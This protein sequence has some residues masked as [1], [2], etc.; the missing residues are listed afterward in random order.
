[1][2]QYNYINILIAEKYFQMNVSNKPIIEVRKTLRPAW[3]RCP[4]DPNAFRELMRP[5]DYQGWL[6]AGGHLLIFGVTAALALYCFVNTHWLGLVIVLFIHGTSASFFKGMA[7]HEL[8]HGTVF[9]TKWLNSLFLRIYSIISWHNFF[10]YAMSH[11][12]HHRYTLHPEGDREV[13][14]PL[15][16]LMKK[17]LYLL[18]IFTINFTGGPVTSGMLPVIKGT[19]QTALGRNGESV[20]SREWS[21]ALYTAHP[22]DRKSAVNW[23][24]AIIFFHSSI[25]IITFYS[26]IWILPLIFTLQQFLANW[27]RYFVGL[28]MHCGLRSNVSDFR[29]CTRSITLDPISEFLYWRMNWHLEHHMFAGV[30]CYNLKKLHKL[31]ADDMP[32]VRTLLGAWREMMEIARRQKLDPD[33]E[34]D[35]PVPQRAPR[36]SRKSSD[37][38][39]SIGDLA[40][41]SIR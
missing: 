4:V 25:L 20:I 41:E 36:S 40:P 13:V 35:T 34:Y 39:D 3:Y 38:T 37:L 15:E 9:K 28:P 10:E 31:V 7:A 1:M 22:G 16:I 19:F 12:Y 32:A 8:G 6:Q 21:S 24:R 18:Q 30:P 23:A 2:S 11:T 27:L 33:Y 26:E 17:P 29:K 14:L 5:S